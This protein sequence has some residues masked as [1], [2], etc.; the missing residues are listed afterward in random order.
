MMMFTLAIVFSL[1]LAVNGVGFNIT[2]YSGL[3][4][5]G[6]SLLLLEP[7]HDLGTIG[8]EDVTKSICG[9]G[10]WLLYE[11]P[12]YSDG[13]FTHLLVT[14]FYAC[15]NLPDTR[16]DKVSSVRFIGT[17]NFYNEVLTLYEHPEGAGGEYLVVRDED[18]LFNFNDVTSTVAVTG[19]SSWTLY[20]DQYYEGSSVCV[21]PSN[22]E[23]SDVFFGYFSIDD[24]GFQNDQV[25]SVRKGC[26]SADIKYFEF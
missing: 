18:N 10:A 1:A 22:I 12:N 15:E 9:Y 7:N 6:A 21:V 4:Q 17:G 24:L 26:F 23:N 11:D 16:Q 20:H 19:N 2:L 13:Q 14:P 3:D 8:F 5:T 25:S